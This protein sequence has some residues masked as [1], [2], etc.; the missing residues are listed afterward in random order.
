MPFGAKAGFAR[1]AV[2]LIG[3]AAPML[4]VRNASAFPALA[5]TV[6]GPQLYGRCFL[7]KSRLAGVPDVSPFCSLSLPLSL[8]SPIG[9]LFF[10]FFSLSCDGTQLRSLRTSVAVDGTYLRRRLSWTMHSTLSHR[11][12]LH[13]IPSTTSQRTLRARHDAQ[14][15]AAR[16]FVTLPSPLACVRF[17]GDCVVS[18]AGAAGGAIELGGAAGDTGDGVSPLSDMVKSVTGPGPGSGGAEGGRRRSG[19]R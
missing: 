1:L 16:R 4:F 3:G 8:T 12:L 19:G 11:Q 17:F 13:G 6:A 2:M 15:R 5:P 18:V 9:R 10:F 14:A 7:E